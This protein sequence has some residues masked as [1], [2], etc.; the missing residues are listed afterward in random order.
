MRD[1]VSNP[2]HAPCPMPHAPLPMDKSEFER[3]KAEEK[4]H[5]RKLRALK[6]Q[7]RGAQR[8]VSSLKALQGMATPEQ[9]ATH[10]EFT[11]KLS[12]DAAMTEARFEIAAEEAARAAQAEADAETTRQSEA[13]ALVRQM[14]AQMGDGPGPAT[15]PSAPR[16][17]DS[18]A[19]AGG[20][21][22]GRAATPDAPAPDDPARGAKSI[23]R[24]RGQ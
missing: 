19:P 20:K 23:G 9:D 3:I 24:P 15:P 22:I 21:T 4:A 14:K 17:T 1:R 18:A 10:D 5:L 13:E 12:R 16:G 11:D 7:H 8:K 6:Q 2:A